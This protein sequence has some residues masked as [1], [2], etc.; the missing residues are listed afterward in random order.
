MG[1]E[2]TRRNTQRARAAGNRT[3]LDIESRVGQA[4]ATPSQADQSIGSRARNAMARIGQRIKN[5]GEE[6]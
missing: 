5:F 3:S 1:T 2:A 6:F 4:N